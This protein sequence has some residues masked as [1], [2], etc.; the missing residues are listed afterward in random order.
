MDDLCDVIEARLNATGEGPKKF[1]I[2]LDI[3]GYEPFVFEKAEKLFKTYEIPA[4]FME[5]GKSVQKLALQKNESSSY[6]MKIRNMLEF[7]KRQ[8]YEPY[9]VNG[10]NMLDYKKWRYDWPWDVYFKQ[11]DMM[12]CPSHVYKL[13]AA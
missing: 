2:K 7:L 11:C 4:L 5:F 10:F 9:E 3:E 13:K 8:N 12:F 1:I 6:A